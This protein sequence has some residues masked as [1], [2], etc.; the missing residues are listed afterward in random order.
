MNQRQSWNIIA[1]FLILIFVMSAASII[2]P[3]KTFSERENRSLAT[4]PAI[5]LQKV[6]SGEFEEDYEEYLKDQFL[7]RDQ[8]I[9]LRTVAERASL[10]KEVHDVYFGK[11]DYLIEKHTGVFDSQQA[12]ANIPVLASFIDDMVARYGNR[13]VSVLLIP[14]AVSILTDKLPSLASPYPEKE[15]LQKV[16]NA[17]QDECWV[18]VT[19]VLEEHKDKELYYRTD[20]HWTTLGAFYVFQNW[21]VSRGYGE[22]RQDSYSAETVTSSFEGTVAAKVGIKVK[23][24]HIE[25]FSRVNEDPCSLVYNETDDV[26]STLYQTSKLDTRSKYDYFLGGNYGLIEITNESNTL[27]RRRIL[28]IKDSYAHCFVPFLI[29]YADQVDLVDLRYYSQSLKQRIEENEYTDVIVLCNAAVF[30]EDTSFPR[31]LM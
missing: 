13:H 26:R 5:S 30:A 31:L 22:I 27:T 9:A 8:W 4:R 24:D 6:L 20:H 16:R 17:V 3:Q 11:D 23:P 15:Y 14:N 10:K 19:S 18:D 28:M 21:A 25:R 1:L 7:W 2:K 29:Q 12:E